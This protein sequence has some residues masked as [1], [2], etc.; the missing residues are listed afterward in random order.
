MDKDYSQA[1]CEAVECLI[2]A[3]L[4]NIA[5]DTTILCTIED[6]SRANEG[7]Y[8]VSYGSAKYEALSTAKYSKGMQV[9]VQ[10]PQGDWNQ[11]KN[12]I[13]QKAID[14]A[15]PITY[16][17]PFDNF[18]DLTANLITNEQR[19]YGGLIADDPGCDYFTKSKDVIKIGYLLYEYGRDEKLEK[20]GYQYLGQI[21]DSLDYTRLGLSAS[22]K[23]LLSEFRP[24]AGIYGLRARVT[25][26]PKKGG[27]AQEIILELNSEHM[28]GN[29]WQLEGF[30]IQERLFDITKFTDCAKI[31]KIVLEFYQK[32]GTF[33]D[34]NGFPFDYGYVMGDP[35]LNPNL[36]IKDVYIALGYDLETYKEE[37]VKIFTNSPLVY[38][39]VNKPEED[40]VEE[41]AV[42][43]NLLRSAPAPQ[44][45]VSISTD[46]AL[47]YNPTRS[48]DNH[49]EL[50]LTWVHRFDTQFRPVTEK[51]AVNYDLIW[52]RYKLGA[53][54]QDIEIG[55]DWEVLSKQKVTLIDD[56]GH[57]RVDYSVKDKDLIEYN[58]NPARTENRNP[59]FNKTWLIPD[60]QKPEEQVKAAIKW[61]GQTFISDP[62][63]FKNCG[64]II[65]NASKYISSALSIRC[66]DGSNGNYPLYR[67]DGAI[68]D[69][70]ESNK[71][72]EFKLYFSTY[73]DEKDKILE[74]KE[75]LEAEYVEWII[76]AGN[77][78]KLNQITEEYDEE[79]NTYQ[80]YYWNPSD[81]FGRKFY[82]QE[83]N[84]YHIEEQGLN[85]YRTLSYQILSNLNGGGKG[86]NQIRVRI[87]KGGIQYDAFLD[88]T[89]VVAGTTGTDFTF[90]LDFEREPALS[91]YKKNKDGDDELQI[92]KEKIGVVAKL[93]D[94]NGND[95]IKNY[96]SSINWSWANNKKV[97]KVKNE[98][99]KEEEVIED[100]FIDWS[101]DKKELNGKKVSLYL[102][103]DKCGVTTNEEDSTK[104][105]I[106][107]ENKN[108]IFGDNCYILKAEVPMKK[109]LDSNND[110]TYK[111]NAYLPIPIRLNYEDDHIQGPTDV[112]YNSLG[113]LD[114]FSYSQVP[115]KIFESA[116]ILKDSI[117][118]EVQCDK[119]ENVVNIKTK[120]ITEKVV[121]ESGN[122]T[123]KEIGKEYYLSP[124]IFYVTNYSEE[125]EIPYSVNVLGKK[126]IEIDNNT[127]EQILWSQPIYIY[128]NK[129]PSSILDKWD[130]ELVIDKD[131][132]ALLAAKIAA[133]RKN[134]DNSFSG[135]IL[136]DWDNTPNEDESSEV[137]LSSKHTGL[138]GF[139]DGA[140][141]YG[142]RDDGSAFIGESGRGR[143]LF[144]GSKGIIKTD[145]WKNT[146]DL[147]DK[148]NKGMLLDFDNGC[149]TMQTEMKIIHTD[150]KGLE[151]EKTFYPTISLNSQ[152]KN[153][154]YEFKNYYQVQTILKSDEAL[155]EDLK[156]ID[157]DEKQK[158]IN[159]FL[160]QYM[161]FEE[162]KYFR[163]DKIPKYKSPP[164]DINDNFKVFW[165]GTLVAKNGLF[166]EGTIFM[167][168]GEELRYIGTNISGG[169]DDSTGSDVE[170]SI[171]ISP[172]SI[173]LD[174]Q[175][176]RN[177]APFNIS[178]NFKVYWDGRVEAN[179]AK[180]KNPNFTGGTGL[181][182]FNS[183][184]TQSLAVNDSSFLADLNSTSF[185]ANEL[186]VYKNFEIKYH[187]WCFID[188]QWIDII[189]L[190]N[191]K[192]NN[193]KNPA[194]PYPDDYTIT[195]NKVEINSNNFN[196]LM[197]KL[198]F[199]AKYIY[200]YERKEDGSLELVENDDVFFSKI[201][202]DKENLVKNLEIIKDIRQK[203]ED[204]KESEIYKIELENGKVMTEEASEY[205]LFLEEIKRGE[206]TNDDCIGVFG[207]VPGYNGDEVTYS[208][209][210]QAKGANSN[211]IIE[212]DKTSGSSPTNIRIGNQDK[213]DIIR[214]SAEPKNQ[215]GI[216]ARFA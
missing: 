119:N 130:G 25:F 17:D 116:D 14:D 190:L 212:G 133:G 43:F 205:E 158:I 97:V 111:L 56:E 79:N 188:N 12:I 57:I 115:Y 189:E 69:N 215:H 201:N 198:N 153:S 193:G 59:S 93:Y 129:Y 92:G 168:K 107:D 179:N 38:R 147:K 100:Y 142:F 159:T 46:E 3:K 85:T 131:N 58:N 155:L 80:S 10:I 128:Q 61:N 76:P 172:Y 53:D 136:G 104:K 196:T 68:L 138:Y 105:S 29:P 15:T 24:I 141:A 180:F 204:G 1:L 44:S 109:S 162:N 151:Q 124:S 60:I 36:F 163:H 33:L 110:T 102:D 183:L 139:H 7:I 91:I 123:E 2:D 67:K 11:Q 171:G 47:T 8:T 106:S 63:V 187:L 152:A 51:Q 83:D 4:E 72:R 170:T 88:L 108:K 16:I 26:E 74:A 175:A 32:L 211:I 145:G 195:Y 23:S 19:S 73:D 214:F 160:S 77:M 54:V 165:D 182:S 118:W 203:E 52:Y 132:N 202:K 40:E 206:S 174:S 167:Q 126:K 37:R 134:S 209:G 62:L 114:E 164:L 94:Y 30:T 173:L 48:E 213:T 146:D 156:K 22:F 50:D 89:F 194:I 35:P 122:E 34:Y 178:D 55:P 210:I 181:G 13:S 137:Y 184:S 200:N 49:K 216:Y 176:P 18:A 20:D 112:R 41:Q 64:E 103:P 199:T 6:D 70:A 144:D 9:Y 5:Y 27:E 127:T 185:A 87:I 42:T 84:C 135:V 78:I 101:K 99:G 113:Y 166:K 71:K 207:L 45:D 21:P 208:L 154:E 98:D 39:I 86:N 31:I 161:D 66:E 75:L 65:N 81:S 197:N 95:I 186:R 191:V 82:L 121:D 177:V 120:V 148:E 28:V 125:K 140:A 169:T 149:L 117:E 192:F 150:E 96:S 157:E 90:L 143:L